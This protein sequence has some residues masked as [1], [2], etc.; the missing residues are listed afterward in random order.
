VVFDSTYQRCIEFLRVS[1]GYRLKNGITKNSPARERRR[2]RLKR[3]RLSRALGQTVLD[4]WP[5][6]TLA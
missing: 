4:V 3:I 2:S 5:E 1:K 6:P